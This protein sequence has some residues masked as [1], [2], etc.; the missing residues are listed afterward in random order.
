MLNPEQI[1]ALKARLPTMQPAEKAWLLERLQEY[2]KRKQMGDAKTSFT[3]FI[4]HVYPHY[5]FGAHHKKLI[6][7]FEAVARGE[8]NPNSFPT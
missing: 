7:L 3:S 1:K 8:K 4:K 2:E 6:S 5:K